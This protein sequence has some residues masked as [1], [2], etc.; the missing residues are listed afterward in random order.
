MQN[1]QESKVGCPSNLFEHPETLI[2]PPSVQKIDDRNRNI[3]YES[4]KE[5]VHRLRSRKSIDNPKRG[6]LP[7]PVRRE[8]KVLQRDVASVIV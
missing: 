3:K 6:L 4:V 1:T 2:I 7:T 5:V 8:D